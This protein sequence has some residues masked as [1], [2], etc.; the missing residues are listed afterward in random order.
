LEQHGPYLPAFSDGY[1]NLAMTDTIAMAIATMPDWSVLKFHIIPLGTGGANEVGLKY[2]FPGTYAVRFETLRSIFMDLAT[3]LGEQG[4]K[5]VFIIHEHGAPN[6]NLALE[7]A[8]DFFNDTYQ[9]TMVNLIGIFRLMSTTWQVDKTKEEE[10]E[11]GLGIH[12]DM[13]ETSTLL[14][15]Q[16]K[17]VDSNYRNAVPISGSDIKSLTDSVAGI[18]NW[19]GYFGSPRL[20]SAGLGKKVWEKTASVAR[21]LVL[22]ILS[23]NLKADTL[24][25][26]TDLTKRDPGSNEV[27]RLALIEDNRRK[28]KQTEWLKK[29][30]F[31]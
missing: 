24:L 27:N 5:Y 6:H 10:I 13:G 16:P 31:K 25:R 11:N 17:L 8:A 2:S 1:W 26:Y 9:G 12:A 3:E 22:D 30:G 28:L 14:Y 4:F 19:P 29:K 15:L 21:Q 20:S 18:A 23:R 7:Q